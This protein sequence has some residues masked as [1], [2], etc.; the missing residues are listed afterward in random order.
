MSEIGDLGWIMGPDA[1]QMPKECFG[2][3]D[4][5]EYK[6]SRTEIYIST[7]PSS[8]HISKLFDRILSELNREKKYQET[9]IKTD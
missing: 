6:P 3:D 9:E 2:D 4:D 5:E 8:E 7:A 1:A